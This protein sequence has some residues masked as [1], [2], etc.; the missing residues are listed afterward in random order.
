MP[1]KYE[2]IA[3]TNSYIVHAEKDVLTNDIKEALA[4]LKEFAKEFS[5]VVL[6]VQTEK[7]GIV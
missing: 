4:Y 6:I 2:V 5:Y 7:K 1:T 3:K